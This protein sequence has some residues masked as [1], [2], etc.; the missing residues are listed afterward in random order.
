MTQSNVITIEN[1]TFSIIFKRLLHVR[2]FDIFFYFSRPP[3]TLPPLSVFIPPDTISS[4]SFSR[5]LCVTGEWQTEIETRTRKHSAYGLRM[6]LKSKS[7]SECHRLNLNI[8]CLRCILCAIISFND[9][10]TPFTGP[11][12]TART[13]SHHTWLAGWLPGWRRHRKTRTC[14]CNFTFITDFDGERCAHAQHIILLFNVHISNVMR[15]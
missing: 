4:I 7:R 9:R 6:R 1:V 12:Q 14:P 2:I 10:Y 5:R 8:K 11:V 13:R 3:P 15:I